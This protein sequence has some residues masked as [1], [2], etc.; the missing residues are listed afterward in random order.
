MSTLSKLIRAESEELHES[1]VMNSGGT[2][3]QCEVSDKCFILFSL[4]S[5]ILKKAH[6]GPMG[7][8]Y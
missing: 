6:Y 1:C 3:V 7:L 8:V 2:P 4:T 5:L